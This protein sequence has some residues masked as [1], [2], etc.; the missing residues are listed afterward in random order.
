MCSQIP[1]ETVETALE[2]VVADAKAA[3]DFPEYPT[4]DGLESR[5]QIVVD[6][7]RDTISTL[8]SRV[9]LGL[10]KPRRIALCGAPNVGKKLTYERIARRGARACRQ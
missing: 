3:L 7:A 5:H 6:G 1:L 8:L 9:E 10:M 2:G 4:G